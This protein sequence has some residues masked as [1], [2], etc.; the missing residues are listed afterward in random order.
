ML[1]FKVKCNRT[2]SLGEISLVK[3]NRV[4]SEPDYI[5]GSSL[6]LQW[7]F[8]SASFSEGKRGIQAHFESYFP[9]KKI[10]II[11]SLNECISANNII[12]N[13]K[14]HIIRSMHT[15]NNIRHVFKNV[16]KFHSKFQIQTLYWGWIQKITNRSIW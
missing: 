16:R 9:K 12:Q 8:A 13:V 15:F 1:V 7:L 3:K 11:S 4:Y 6:A 5:T 14:V 2:R 10:K